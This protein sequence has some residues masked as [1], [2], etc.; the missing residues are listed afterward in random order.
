MQL[1]RQYLAHET[2]DYTFELDEYRDEHG[3]QLMLSHIRMKRW[4]A[5]VLKRLLR[6]WRVL[7]QCVTCPL[8]ACPQVD[9]ARWV[10]F[11][12]RL[13]YRPLQKIICNDGLERPLY[14]HT[15]DQ[16]ACAGNKPIARPA[17]L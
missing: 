2:S 11:V 6:D 17:A 16:V 12:T 14:I 8:F 1:V 15:T 5:S 4:S 9:D 3:Q 13:G 10:K 7:R